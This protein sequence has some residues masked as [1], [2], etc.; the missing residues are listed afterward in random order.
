MLF[1]RLPRSSKCRSHIYS[2]SFYSTQSNFNFNVKQRRGKG[3]NND[4]VEFCKE[5]NITINLFLP[6]CA[7]RLDCVKNRVALQVKTKTNQ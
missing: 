6:M 2:F 5:L 1:S 7:V 3:Q 4:G